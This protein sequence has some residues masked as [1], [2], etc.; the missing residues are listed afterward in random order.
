MKTLIG[1]IIGYVLGVVSIFVYQVFGKPVLPN[2]VEE[3]H[4]KMNANDKSFGDY[5]IKSE[6]GRMLSEEYDKQQKG[7]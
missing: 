6:Y 3:H 4:E 2:V 1:I 7:E 5:I